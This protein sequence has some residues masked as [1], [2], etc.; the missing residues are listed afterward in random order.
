MNNIQQLSHEPTNELLAI[1]NTQT[2]ATSK[3]CAQLN[4]RVALVN[5]CVLFYY[6]RFNS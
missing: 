6:V 2:K 3:M 5:F 4:T 1:M